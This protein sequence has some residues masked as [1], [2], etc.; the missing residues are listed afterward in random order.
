MIKHV[1]KQFYQTMSSHFVKRSGYS[2]L[3]HYLASITLMMSFVFL[4]ADTFAIA[5]L[6]CPGLLVFSTATKGLVF[7][8]IIIISLL[9]YLFLFRI[10]KI[11]EG[12]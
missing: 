3:S 10:F 6:I 1:I 7:I 11:G 5:N 12:R 8:V 4:I 9:N 2:T